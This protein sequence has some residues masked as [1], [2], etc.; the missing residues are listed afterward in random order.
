MKESDLIVGKTYY[1]K[2]DLDGPD[3][4]W[5]GK[6]VYK[7]L[8]DIDYQYDEKNYKFICEDGIVGNFTIEC[9]IEECVEEECATDDDIILEQWKIMY[10]ALKLI[11]ESNDWIAIDAIERVNNLK[12]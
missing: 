4:F 12:K 11:A 10:E 9:V 8:S 7:G 6:A 1:I 2:Y 5:E 3:H